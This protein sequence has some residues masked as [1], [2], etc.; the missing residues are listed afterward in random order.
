MNIG[1][2]LKAFSEQN[3]YELAIQKLKHSGSGDNELQ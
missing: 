2:R 3:R 1:S